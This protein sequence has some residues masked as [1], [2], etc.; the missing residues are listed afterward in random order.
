MK[1]NNTRIGWFC[2][3]PWARLLSAWGLGNSPCPNCVGHVVGTGIAGALLVYF[4]IATWFLSLLICSLGM[5]LS[6]RTLGGYLGRSQVCIV[7]CLWSIRDH[8]YEFFLESI[9]ITIYSNVFIYRLSFRQCFFWKDNVKGIINV[10]TLPRG[11]LHT[12]KTFCNKGWNFFCK[13]MWSR[14]SE[15][16][17]GLRTM[18]SLCQRG[19]Q[20]HHR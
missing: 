5:L 7:H 19:V 8:S 3:A 10:Y 9:Y 2:D 4:W 1:C 13:V 14:S 6:W 15:N 16:V 11:Q 17:K 12:N 18:K 20:Y